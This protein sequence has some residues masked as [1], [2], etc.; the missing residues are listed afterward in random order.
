MNMRCGT[1]LVSMTHGVLIQL[2]AFEQQTN[3]QDKNEHSLTR[4]HTHRCT[5]ATRFSNPIAVLCAL[6]FS[7]SIHAETTAAWVESE[8]QK[9]YQS[10]LNWPP[11]VRFIDKIKCSNSTELAIIWFLKNGSD[12]TNNNKNNI[13][14]RHTLIPS[15]ISDKNRK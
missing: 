12:S 8:E 4:S 15:K 3:G 7:S 2:N 1:V 10:V 11:V 6:F 5:R 14:D 13:E 9:K